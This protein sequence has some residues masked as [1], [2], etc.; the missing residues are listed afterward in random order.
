MIDKYLEQ[1]QE[2]SPEGMLEDVQERLSNLNHSEPTEGE[3][4]EGTRAEAT[5]QSFWHSCISNP[6]GSSDQ[7][8]SSKS[9]TTLEKESK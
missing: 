9:N 8:N 4:N 1:H 5:H 6:H 2:E 7:T 3:N